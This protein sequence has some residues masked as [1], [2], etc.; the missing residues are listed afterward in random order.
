MNGVAALMYHHISPQGGA[1]TVHPDLFREQLSWLNREGYYCLTASELSAWRVGEFF[2][3][4]KAVILTFDD[5]WLDNWVYA[6][7][8]LLDAGVSAILSVI[9]GW[10][11]EGR[12]RAMGF[13]PDEKLPAHSEAMGLAEDEATRDSVVMRWSELRQAEAEGIFGLE[14]HSHS[15]GEWWKERDAGA[16][17]SAFEKDLEKSRTTFEQ[18]LGRAPCQYCWPRGQ[19]TESMRRAV[20]RVGFEVEFS[21]LRGSNAPGRHDR[22]IRRIN[23]E[24]QPLSWFKRRVKFYSSPVLAALP[25]LTHQRL[26]ARRLARQYHGRIAAREFRVPVARLI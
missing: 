19:F 12:A 21:T 10:P 18:R 23:V 26:Q 17:Q 6:A 7:P 25:A 15:H 4:A 1:Y 8:A 5:G 16:I 3:P 20:A 9:T 11:G 14:C 13:S 24:D 22:L 2:P